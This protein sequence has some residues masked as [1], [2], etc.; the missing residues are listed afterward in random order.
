MGEIKVKD[1]IEKLKKMDQ[2][3]I[4]RKMEL[5]DNEPIFSSIEICAEYIGKNYINDNGDD[6]NGNIVVIF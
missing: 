5:T 2:E 4:V 6:E 3:A 1:L